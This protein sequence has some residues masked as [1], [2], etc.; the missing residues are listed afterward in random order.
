MISR[1]KRLLLLAA[2]ATVGM[3][4][5]AHAADGVPGVDV[6][7]WT[8]DIDWASVAAGGGKFAFVQATEGADYTNPRFAA[9]YDGAAAAGLV[10]GAYHFA[11]PHETDGT[12]QADYFLQ[13]GG[14]WV[15]DGQTLPGVLDIEDNPYKDTNGKN[16]CYGLSVED[17]VTW[18]KDFT[19]KYRDATGRHAIIYTTTSWWQTCTGNS[20]KFKSNPLWLAR[21]GG[22][23]GEL[24]KSWKRW[25]FWQS[26]DKGPL[27]G[28]GNTFNGTESQLATLAN[29]PASVSVSGQAKNR[30]TYTVT[31]KNTGPHPVKDIKLS[32][33]AFGGQTV[34]R[35]PGCDFSGTAVRCTIGEL[36]RGQ[37]KTFTFTTKPRKSKGAVGM[38]V[39]VGSV[40]LTLK[41]R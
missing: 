15:S 10:R 40:K 30:K 25:T 41:S 7:N 31:I 34:V 21:W 22:D 6:S 33:R 9:Q 39:T 18:L 4:G 19:K 1:V 24:P 36:P 35:A 13:H 2:I 8:G 32:G 23:P 12:T 16:N 17:M 14:N 20:A 26:A 11:Q 38:Y 28:G 3:T 29:P 37:N 27:V 5:V